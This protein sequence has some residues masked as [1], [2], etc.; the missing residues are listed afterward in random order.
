MYP[1]E[2]LF[3][4]I[5]WLGLWLIEVA[6]GLRDEWRLL[7]L[8]WL[9]WTVAFLHAI[10][11]HLLLHEFVKLVLKI[12]IEV[13]LVVKNIVECDWLARLKPQ[14]RTLRT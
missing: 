12:L 11:L 10:G 8:H 13:V 2:F 4:L 3:I 7:H 9:L 6:T 1:G 5:S 14:H